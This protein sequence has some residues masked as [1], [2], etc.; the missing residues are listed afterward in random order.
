MENLIPRIFTT[1]KYTSSVRK[2]QAR[3]LYGLSTLV[4]VALTLVL[5][6]LP[7]TEGVIPFINAL[8]VGF[9]ISVGTQLA[10]WLAS[11]GAI[12][13][14][15][16]GRYEI[17]SWLINVL[18]LL[19]I[20]AI[21]I[22]GNVTSGLILGAA[23]I[24]VFGTL[25]LGGRGL[26]TI[27]VGISIA[28]IVAPSFNP[29][30]PA[31]NAS[32]LIPLAAFL[33]LNYAI[34]L[35][36]RSSEREGSEVESVE[37][38]KLAEINT[39]ITRQASERTSLDETLKNTLD[40]ILESYPQF[41]HAQVFLIDDDGVQ[42]RLTAS[43]GETG[44]QLIEK[45]HSLAVGTLSVIGQT[46]FKGHPVIARS[47]DRD[48]IHR[49]NQLLPQTRVEAAFPLRIGDKIIGALDL[50]SREELAMG[51]FDMLTFQSLANS[52]SLAIDSI[53]QFEA[54]KA[55]IAENQ[56][57]TEQTRNALRDVE[58]LNQRLIGRA[59]S[60]YLSGKG[61][62]LGLDIDL[63][64]DDVDVDTTWTNTL[65]DAVQGVSIVQDDNVIAVPLKVR[66]VLV[67]AM[68]FE[69]SEGVEFTPADME[70]VQEVSD[71]FGL[72]AE[73]TRLVEESQR[74][75]QRESLINEISSRLQSAINVESTLA[76]AARSLSDTLQANRVMI[77][78]GE[79]RAEKPQPNGHT[80]GARE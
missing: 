34:V 12:L 61:N 45:G 65:S 18:L 35:L 5:F 27:G 48:T 80:N 37:R 60:E 10:A 67:G 42:A 44:K 20:V 4:V 41:Y 16:V 22:T 69:L 38:F 68:E 57:L 52:L 78:L 17:G 56:R 49:E 73:N 54:A 21:L 75:A 9:D 53:Q 15:R 66:G 64:T 63:T 72:A 76:E 23:F 36:V 39:S 79:L 71:R 51:E 11:I 25:T 31:I 55:R 14:V 29:N 50:Q 59:W 24:I 19:M 43:T 62:Q 33:A 7:N 40:L 26:G 77:Q 6:L 2:A 30:M 32:Q 46:T 74:V 58:R 13:L 70:L 28:F 8:E 3:L 1:E 47:G